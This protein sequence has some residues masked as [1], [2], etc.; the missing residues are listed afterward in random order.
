MS[1]DGGQRVLT[2]EVESTLAQLP[3]AAWS[4]RR[5]VERLWLSGYQLSGRVTIKGIVQ[6]RPW[7]ST[8]RPQE[9]E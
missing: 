8:G 6:H 5:T 9:D 1:E 2:V 7:T 4:F 3:D